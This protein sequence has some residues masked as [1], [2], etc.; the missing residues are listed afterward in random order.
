MHRVMTGKTSMNLMYLTLG[1]TLW[2]PA[3]TTA[4]VSG[5]LSPWR[6]EYHRCDQKIPNASVNLPPALS[7]SIGVEFSPIEL[8]TCWG[9]FVVDFTGTNTQP[10]RSVAP[11]GTEQIETLLVDLKTPPN[12]Q[13]A[14]EET[15]VLVSASGGTGSGWEALPAATYVGTWYG[16]GTGRHCYLSLSGAGSFLESDWSRYTTL[17]V[18]VSAW[19]GSFRVG[20][21]VEYYASR[22]VPPG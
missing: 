7:G 19:Q 20:A 1:L 4:Q 17:R 8:P 11:D 16:Y 14:C 22:Q 10:P 2:S 6:P 21:S 3:L 18:A 15:T 12:Y 9:S 5:P 13:D